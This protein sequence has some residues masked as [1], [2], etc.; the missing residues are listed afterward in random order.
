[1]ERSC[2]RRVLHLSGLLTPLSRRHRSCESVCVPRTYNITSSRSVR[3]EENLS[4][5]ELRD[6]VEALR[7][8]VDRGDH[9]LTAIVDPYAYG[10]S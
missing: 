4:E 2:R 8:T 9:M 5:N 3:C 7:T 6:G 10:L 1:M